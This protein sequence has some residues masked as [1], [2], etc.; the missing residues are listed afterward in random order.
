ML[1]WHGIIQAEIYS[2]RGRVIWPWL[3]VF[4]LLLKVFGR[5]WN[6]CGIPLDSRASCSRPTFDRFPYNEVSTIF[7]SFFLSFSLYR[8][9]YY[10]IQK[11]TSMCETQ[12]HRI[13]PCS[14]TFPTV[15]LFL[16]EQTWEHRGVYKKSLK[17]ILTCLNKR[18]KHVQ[19]SGN[20]WKYVPLNNT[21]RLKRKLIRYKVFGKNEQPIY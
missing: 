18:E 8:R 11:N 9:K 3:C 12:L 16:F 15:L 5:E 10:L 19:A 17:K 20:K 7:S 13:F 21:V 1:I 4:S 6:V 14:R 2:G